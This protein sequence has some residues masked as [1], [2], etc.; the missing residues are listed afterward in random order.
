MFT[1]KDLDQKDGVIV[2]DRGE[3]PAPANEDDNRLDRFQ[4]VKG[5]N[6]GSHYKR[7]HYPELLSGNYT[8]S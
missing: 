8:T 4:R 6:R 7:G 3:D 2:S 1:L 5:P